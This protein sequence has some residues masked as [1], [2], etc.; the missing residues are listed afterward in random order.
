MRL[1]RYAWRARLSGALRSR[2]RTL[3]AALILLGFAAAGWAYPVAGVD[4]AGSKSPQR[5]TPTRSQPATGTTKLISAE[6]RQI[7]VIAARADCLDTSETSSG[8]PGPTTTQG[9]VATTAAT[10]ALSA[11]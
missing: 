7:R 10:R 5:T 8:R 11:L 4:P 3:L 6:L 9:V 2:E 1:S